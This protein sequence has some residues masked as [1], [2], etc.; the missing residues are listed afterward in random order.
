VRLAGADD[1][2]SL[3][4]LA[5]AGGA[6]ARAVPTADFGLLLGF[7][8]GDAWAPETA[9]RTAGFVTVGAGASFGL[10]CRSPMT[11]DATLPEAN[12]SIHLGTITTQLYILVNQTAMNSMIYSL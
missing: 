9:A 5:A 1:S 3:S 4:V 6:L 8:F 11:R 7:G 2:C 10:P 12:S